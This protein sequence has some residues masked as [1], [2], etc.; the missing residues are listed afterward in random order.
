MTFNNLL[1][2]PLT[3]AG[4]IMMIPQYGS[5]GTGDSPS[6]RVADT[7]V[8]NFVDPRR[9]T[10]AFLDKRVA[11]ELVTSVSGRSWRRQFFGNALRVGGKQLGRVLGIAPKHPRTSAT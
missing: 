10:A 4:K 7:V 1:L 3:P 9:H 5:D 6:Q 8:Q 2:E 11:R